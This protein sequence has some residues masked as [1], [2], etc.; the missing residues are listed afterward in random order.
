M[1]C[2]VLCVFRRWVHVPVIHAA[3]HIDCDKRVA[4]FSIA[5]HACGSLPITVIC[6]RTAQLFLAELRRPE[7]PLSG[8]P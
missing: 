7:G 8:S 3:S 1:L 5:M 6:L 2:N 4:W